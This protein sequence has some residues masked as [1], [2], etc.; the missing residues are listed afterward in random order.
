MKR[1]V[2]PKIGAIA[3]SAGVPAALSSRPCTAEAPGAPSRDSSWAKNSPWAASL[4]NTRPAIEITISSSG[5]IE[6]IV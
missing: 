2:S 1:K 4:P 3:L 6:N 5:A